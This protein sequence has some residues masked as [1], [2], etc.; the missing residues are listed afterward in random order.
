M[1]KTKLSIIAYL[2]NGITKMPL[3]Q[4]LKITNYT[5]DSFRCLEKKDLDDLKSNYEERYRKGEY[6]GGSE[7]PG[8]NNYW[9]GNGPLYLAVNLFYDTTTHNVYIEKNFS[10]QRIDAMIV[11]ACEVFKKLCPDAN[12]ED[13][14]WFIERLTHVISSFIGK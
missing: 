2:E 4:V 14:T 11:L 10:A 1:E 3:E 12:E 9:G 8:P 13:K 7:M 6:E 5:N